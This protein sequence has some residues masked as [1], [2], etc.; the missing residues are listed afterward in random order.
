VID[1][2]GRGH[3]DRLAD[4]AHAR[5]RGHRPRLVRRP[6]KTSSRPDKRCLHDPASRMR[7]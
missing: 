4:M 7:R 1:I 5:A 3:A 2:R 6:L